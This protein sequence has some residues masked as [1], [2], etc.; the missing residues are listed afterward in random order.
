MRF[1]F[2]ARK[3]CTCPVVM[4][5]GLGG[6]KPGGS[7]RAG[8]VRWLSRGERHPRQSGDKTGRRAVVRQHTMPDERLCQ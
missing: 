3:K 8:T 7:F 5:K 6:E 2:T 4:G 1:S